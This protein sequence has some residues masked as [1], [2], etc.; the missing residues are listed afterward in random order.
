MSEGRTLPDHETC[1]HRWYG[2]SCEQFEAMLQACGRQ[3]EACGCPSENS[4]AGK[5]VVDHDGTVGNWAVR[6]LLCTTCNVTFRIDRP[7]PEWAKGYL[8]NPWWAR[9]LKELGISA[10]IPEPSDWTETLDGYFIEPRVQASDGSLWYRRP[11]GWER[12]YKSGE[13]RSWS[14]LISTFG[15]HN[16]AVYHGEGR[17]VPVDE[18]PDKRP[19][20][21]ECAAMLEQLSP[22]EILA[23]I[24]AAHK[25][26]T[27][28]SLSYEG[29]MHS[30]AAAARPKLRTKNAGVT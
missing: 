19:S 14:S 25:R 13:L 26:E 9:M 2:L 27:A 29:L 11:G 12:G 24:K 18:V 5:L 16:L 17:P 10:D 6:G 7:D 28:W 1:R 21:A 22:A 30:A 20:A 8:A 4:S 3:C 15:P 23:C